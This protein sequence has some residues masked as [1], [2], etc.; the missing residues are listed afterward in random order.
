MN[1]FLVRGTVD[2]KTISE[3]IENVSPY[4]PEAFTT[5]ERKIIDK[6]KAMGYKKEDIILEHIEIKK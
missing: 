1:R 5:E 6:F 4:A 2:G 3:L